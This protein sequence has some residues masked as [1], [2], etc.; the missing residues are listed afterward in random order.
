MKKTFLLLSFVI[1]IISLYNC[2]P[3]ESEVKLP[4][5]DKNFFGNWVKQNDIIISIEP[6]KIIVSEYTDK[7]VLIEIPNS[8]PKTK[9]II[10]INNNE[11]NYEIQVDNGSKFPLTHKFIFNKNENT[12]QYGDKILSKAIID[13]ELNVEANDKL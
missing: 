8:K 4:V 9:E 7:S 1:I 10:V 11:D 2:S 12:I 13:N 3:K 6:E 5:P